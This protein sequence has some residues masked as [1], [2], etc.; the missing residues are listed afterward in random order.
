MENNYD[1][2]PENEN[3]LFG[4]D[5]KLPF[6][7]PEGYF[8]FFAARLIARIEVMEELKMFSRLSEIEKRNS[9]VTPANYFDISKNQ[10]EVKCELSDFSLLSSIPKKSLPKSAAL[11]VENILG[12]TNDD[13]LKSLKTLSSIRKENTFSV[14]PDY[15]ETSSASIKTA[16]LASGKQGRVVSFFV[17]PKML[18][19][20]AAAIAAIVCAAFY[21]HNTKPEM[22]TGDCHTLACLEK[23]EILNEKTIGDFNEE[24]L[25]E[26]V[27]ADQLNVQLSSSDSVKVNENKK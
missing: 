9:Y 23:N 15:F 24:D 19:A 22:V 11:S 7:V 14:A 17:R 25:Y 21:F 1:S 6:I 18:L 26:M 3:F 20:Y 13:E 2:N 27:D 10:I 16:V 8:D 4:K 5:K 12:K